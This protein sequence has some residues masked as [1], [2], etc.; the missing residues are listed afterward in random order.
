MYRIVAERATFCFPS[1]ENIFSC[2]HIL[3]FQ[4]KSD[5]LC[6]KKIIHESFTFCFLYLAQVRLKTG[7][8]IWLHSLAWTCPAIKMDLKGLLPCCPTNFSKTGGDQ[9]LDLLSC[10]T[11]LMEPSSQWGSPGAIY[12][13]L[14]LGKISFPR[15][16]QYYL[17]VM[18]LSFWWTFG[19][20]AAF[21]LWLLWDASSLTRKLGLVEGHGQGHSCPACSHMFTN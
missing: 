19:Y 20:S 15:A 21:L 8:F 2:I 9:R 16:F 17:L 13:L 6:L 11:L 3:L 10:S 4:W 1:W 18:F 14:A 12:F 5:P 7:V